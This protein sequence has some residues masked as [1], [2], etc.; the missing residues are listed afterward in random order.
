M[1]KFVSGN[2]HSSASAFSVSDKKIRKFNSKIYVFLLWDDKLAWAALNL[3]YTLIV[4]LYA[5]AS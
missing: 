2:C 1:K 5:I 3:V 4:Q